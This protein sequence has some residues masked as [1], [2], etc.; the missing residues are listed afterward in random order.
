V[1][2]LA[3]LLIGIVLTHRIAGP[4]FRVKKLLDDLG[5]GRRDVPGTGS[6]GRRA[7]R[8]VRLGPPW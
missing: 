8:A 1:F 6:G 3:V 2:A 5:E 4:V 7:A